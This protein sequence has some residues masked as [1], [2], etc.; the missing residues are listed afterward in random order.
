MNESI[1]QIPTAYTGLIW[2]YMVK[3][4]I[5]KVKWYINIVIYFE[6]IFAL[7]DLPK[8]GRNRATDGTMEFT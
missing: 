1:V 5:I 6:N 8:R 2:L 7:P 4:L 3:W